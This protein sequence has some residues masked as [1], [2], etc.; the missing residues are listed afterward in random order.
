MSHECWRATVSHINHCG[1]AEA[2]LIRS[3]PVTICCSWHLHMKKT[4]RCNSS[5][6]RERTRWREAG[7]ISP[8]H[9]GGAELAGID[10]WQLLIA[11]FWREQDTDQQ[12]VGGKGRKKSVV[13]RAASVSHRYRL[14]GESEGTWH[15]R[16]P[17]T[18][19]MLTQLKWIP[20]GRSPPIKTLK[21]NHTSLRTLELNPS[22]SVF[23]WHNI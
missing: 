3:T 10:T 18:A 19:D 17:V 22:L 12:R 8:S 5:D 7:V 9:T 14:A 21:H 23:Y 1:H 16:G 4:N 20:K 2:S 11:A 15:L 13:A 6:G